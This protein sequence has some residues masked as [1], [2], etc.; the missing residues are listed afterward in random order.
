MGR[1][2]QQRP[3]GDEDASS[4]NRTAHE[5]LAPPFPTGSGKIGEPTV[6]NWALGFG[7]DCRRRVD[8]AD[9]RSGIGEN[10]WVDGIKKRARPAGVGW[11][12]GH[13][14]D[15]PKVWSRGH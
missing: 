2:R 1:G 12:D 10:H 5:G 13:R 3:K 4:K 14:P 8:D 6:V 11:S 7:V 15:W 9:T